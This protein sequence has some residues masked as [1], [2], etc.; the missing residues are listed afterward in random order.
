M[1]SEASAANPEQQG[2]GV[3]RVPCEGA[4]VIVTEKS[5]DQYFLWQ[6]PDGGSFMFPVDQSVTITQE[7]DRLPS[8][9]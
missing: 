8:T 1:V 7:F 3:M 9:A 5:G 4:G 6:C 2:G